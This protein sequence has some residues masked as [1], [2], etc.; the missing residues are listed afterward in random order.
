MYELLSCY[1]FINEEIKY[2][3]KALKLKRLKKS[4]LKGENYGFITILT[5]FLKH[6]LHKLH[7][8]L[9]W[10]FYTNL[11][12]SADPSSNVYY[13]S[14][15]K[16][17]SLSPI[18]GASTEIA[19]SRCSP[20]ASGRGCG[21]RSASGRHGDGVGR[22]REARHVLHDGYAEGWSANQVYVVRSW[23]HFDQKEVHVSHAY[24]HQGAHHRI[25]HQK[26]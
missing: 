13:L 18:V 24:S 16:R 4:F 21:S 15:P 20:R 22:V 2:C 11:T 6:V 5:N 10:H 14:P 8:Q 26:S 12:K 1:E 7:I 3:P 19:S 9:S 25:A 23:K 17:A